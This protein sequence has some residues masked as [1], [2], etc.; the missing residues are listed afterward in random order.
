MIKKGEMIGFQLKI[1]IKKIEKLNPNKYEPESPRNNWL[2]ILSKNTN[3]NKIK[4]Y[5]IEILLIVII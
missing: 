3:D 1:L 5:I 2:L 4:I